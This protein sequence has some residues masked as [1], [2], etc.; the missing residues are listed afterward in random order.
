MFPFDWIKP[1]GSRAASLGLPCGRVQN[2]A[3]R[4]MALPPQGW[5]GRRRRSSGACRWTSPASSSTGSSRALPVALSR[6]LNQNPAAGCGMRSTKADI[7]A[8][9]SSQ[10][11]TNWLY[12]FASYLGDFEC[13]NPLSLGRRHIPQ[14]Q[15]ATGGRRDIGRRLGGHQWRRQWS[16][17]KWRLCHHRC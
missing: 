5:W 17:G 13:V 2:E 3:H 15:A 7:W 6:W 14:P 1:L 11:F 12:A 16:R 4:P 8:A 9:V 10:L